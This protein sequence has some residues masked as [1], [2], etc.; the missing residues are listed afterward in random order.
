MSY[1]IEWT[2]GPVVLGAALA[3]PA[4]AGFRPDRGHQSS[5]LP[6]LRPWSR[7]PGR[8]SRRRTCSCAPS[9]GAWRS[10]PSPRRQAPPTIRALPR[11]PNR[12]QQGADREY[13][14]VTDRQRPSR[15]SLPLGHRADPAQI[16]NFRVPKANLEGVYGAGPVGSPYLYSKDDPAKLLLSAT[17]RD[18]PRNHEGIALIG[19]PRNDVHL[20]T[21]QMVVAFI[22]LH[23]RLVDHL[24]QD[25]DAGQDIFEQA[26]RAASWHY[27][28]VILREFLPALIG[29]QLTAELL[30]SGPQ[31]YRVERD[32]Y[33]PF[34]FADARARVGRGGA[35]VV[36]HPQGSRRPARR[37][38]VGSGRR[39]D[40]R[41]GTGG[42]HRRRP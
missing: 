27:Q 23:N 18:V 28:H 10:G 7:S 36:L 9:V 3:P 35:A 25:E 12:Q 26:R 41:R 17:G 15:R 21:S 29:A 33:I 40:R 32:A 16:R 11:S 20:F 19:D 24:R 38:P 42:H 34:E 30:D 14:D 5:R 1:G 31:L 4:S 22:K 37:R 2:A 6:R 8:S 13:A 39:P